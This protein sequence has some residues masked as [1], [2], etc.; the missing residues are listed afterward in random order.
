MGYLLAISNFGGGTHQGIFSDNDQR[1]PEDE[2]FRA[3]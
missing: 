3:E 2:R 1:L